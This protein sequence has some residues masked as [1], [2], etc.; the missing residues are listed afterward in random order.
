LSRLL[1]RLFLV[2][3]DDVVEDA[4]FVERAASALAACGP[5]CALQ[6]RAHRAEGDRLWQ[7]AR[8][9]KA[10]AESAGATLWLNDRLD[11]ALAVAAHGVQ[12]G[13][14]SFDIA[15]ARRL[16][17]SSCWIGASVHS[18]TEAGES[19][20]RG[21]DVA[22]LG[23]VYATASHPG[24]VPLGLEAL[25]QATQGRPIV[26]I[27]GITLQR[28]AEVVGAGAWGVAVLSGVWQADDAA[29]AVRRYRQALAEA[30]R[31]TH[32]D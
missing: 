14:G 1:P 21:A 30:V 31:G 9:L 4:A 26:A 23:S 27:G 15:P 32:S 25:R 2:T 3:N 11:V 8:R 20:R 24:R 28:V 5:D 10:A 19:L 29:V 17:G 22:V 7:L 16:L 18:P 12:L 13:A 6:L